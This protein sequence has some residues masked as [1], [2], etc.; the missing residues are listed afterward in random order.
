[1]REVS[2]KRCEADYCLPMLRKEEQ[3]KGAD[4]A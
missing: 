4:A 1:M 3:Q 2:W